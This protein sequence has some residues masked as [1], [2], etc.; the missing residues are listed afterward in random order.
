MATK[1]YLSG[2]H[3]TDPKEDRGAS[4]NGFIE[5][6]EA[7]KLA[8]AVYTNL[9]GR[10][11]VVLDKEDTILKETLAAFGRLIG[12]KDIAVEFHFNASDNPSATGVEVLVPAPPSALEQLI[13][14]DLS[15]TISKVLGIRD[16]GVKTE[17][18]SARGKLGWMRMN[19][20]NILV[21]VCFISNLNDMKQYKLHF[22]TLANNIA[23]VLN[24]Y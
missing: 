21:E 24:K 2:G 12:S 6:V 9:L 23:S 5:G 7:Y 13:A 10:K 16:R 17:A 11:N 8:D 20:E 22:N 18:Q 19:C 15:A 14:T 1:I 3:S 4:G